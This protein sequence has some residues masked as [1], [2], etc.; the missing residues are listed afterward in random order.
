MIYKFLKQIIKAALFFFF[1]K[2][3]VSGKEHIPANGPLIIVANHPNTFMDPLLI[4]AITS[5]RI[6]FVANASIFLNKFISRVF[7]Y[8]HVIPIYRKK[9]IQPGEKLDNRKAFSKCHEYLDQ[10]GTL[11]IFP[12]G[13]SYYELKLREIKT[14]TARI[15]LSFEDLKGFEG[16]LKIIPVA[17]DYSD[18]I[19]FRSVVSVT[20]CRPLSVHAYRLAYDKNEFEAVDELTEAIRKELGDIIPQ[21][22]GKEQ[23]EF[24]VRA[25]QFYL[26]FYE[27]KTNAKIRPKQS[28]EL[29]NRVSKA[30][31]YIQK[32]NSILYTDTQAKLLLFFKLLKEERLTANVISDVML[33][34]N[35]LL[36][37]SFYLFKFILLF[38]LYIFGLSTNYV[39]Y[40]MTAKIFKSLQLDIE[41][42]APVQMITGFF[43]FPV[44]YGLIIWLFRMY[45]SEEFWYSLLLFGLMPITGYI[46]LY[47][48]AELR[49]FFKRMHFDFFIRKDKKVAIIQLKDEIVNNMEEARNYANVGRESALK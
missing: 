27:S 15:A 2:I 42:K 14:G 33:Q 19:Q 22:S 16:N 47:Y 45:I 41:Y 23:E 12:E 31:R 36:V 28:L 20:V 39:P 24:L 5:Q 18:S 40:M 43:T 9:D 10:Q 11:L 48:Y 34:K 3:V 17:L 38:P 35:G 13:T 4:A 32:E 8:F 44:Y 37:Y 6:G 7:R 1:R 26:A 46:T 29:R 25:H 49:R 21:T 30:L